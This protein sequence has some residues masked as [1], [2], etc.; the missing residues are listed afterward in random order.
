VGV[1]EK[2]RA[3]LLAESIGVHGFVLT[4]RDLLLRAKQRNRNEQTV[5]ENQIT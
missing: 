5:A 1:L 2:V 3:F 4:F